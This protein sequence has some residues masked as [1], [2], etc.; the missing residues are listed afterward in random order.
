MDLV[1]EVYKLTRLLPDNE[2]Y[3]LVSQMRR[4]AISIPSN[5]AEGF[6]RKGAADF[7]RFLTIAS[8]SAAE[9]ETQAE[10]CKKLYAF[11]KAQT[12]KLDG[13]LLEVQKMLSSMIANLVSRQN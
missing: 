2:K 11:K 12:T 7:V 13:L 1:V 10:L 9:L 5:I 4:A 6:K 3:G 8:G